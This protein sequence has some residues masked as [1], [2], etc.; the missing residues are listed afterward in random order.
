MTDATRTRTRTKTKTK[1]KTRPTTTLNGHAYHKMKAGHP[2]TTP[3][4]NATLKADADA[5]R[6][7]LHGTDK[8]SVRYDMAPTAVQ[9]HNDKAFKLTAG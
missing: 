3:I 9:F 8:S 6:A 2:T 7:P 4:V 1:T 5:Y